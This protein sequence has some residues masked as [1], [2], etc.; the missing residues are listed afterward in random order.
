MVSRLGYRTDIQGLRAVAVV[1][2]MAFHFNPAWL[3]GGFI[4]VDIFLVISGFLITS[5]LLN[6]KDKPDF[7]VSATLRRFYISRLKRIL[8]AYFFMLLVTA[9]LAA[10]FFLPADFDTFK[11]SLRK[12]VL[13]NSNSH[14]A[15]FSDYFA[16]ASYEQPLLHTWSLAVEVKFYL[17]AP[18]LILFFP[19]GSLKWIFAALLLGLTAVAEYHLR[20]LGVEQATYYSLLARLPEFFA[21][22][23]SALYL[24]TKRDG[25]WCAKWCSNLGLALI[26]SA[27]AIQPLLGTFPGFAALLPVAGSMLLLRQPAKGWVQLILGSKALGW[28]GTLSYSLY[29]WHWPVLALLRYYTGTE[30]LN[31]GFS[32]CFILLTLLLAMFS[33]FFIEKYFHRKH[34]SKKQTI[35]WLLLALGMLA[36]SRSITTINAALTSEQLPIEYRRYADPTIICHG[37]IVGDCLQGDLTSD[38]EVLVLGDS[39][40]AMLND[41]FDYLGNNIGFKARIV[42]A[43]SCVTIPEF[44]YLRIPE[45]ARQSCLNQI[46]KANDFLED[47]K[48]VFLA[49][50]WSYHTASAEF[51]DAL[52]R[53]I[54]SR[55][56]TRI[57]ILSQVPRFSVNVVR[58]RRFSSLGFPVEFTRDAEYQSANFYL[59]KL[60]R[61]YPQVVFLQLDSLEVFNEAPLYSQDLIYFDEHHLNELGVK[62]YARF[63]KSIFDK[64]DL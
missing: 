21:G 29:L 40:A 13:F 32:L 8:P 35:V 58:L 44:D 54:I 17:L 24:T 31:L 37:Q 52:D 50:S 41:F 7:S 11:K 36:V 56:N 48:V 23:L 64:L 57:F 9:L 39:H 59:K 63:S 38:K 18:F 1:A 51:K 2:V 5:I 15:Q 47:A 12:A 62:S 27:A 33:Y 46:E 10:I 53:F 20:F 19:L 34:G 30:V 45:K 3:P 42:T 49:G 60:S 16:P 4:G 61:K 6:E 14:F 25:D 22:S 26:V 43:S 55:P 28:I